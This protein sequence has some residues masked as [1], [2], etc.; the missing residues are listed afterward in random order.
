MLAERGW[1][2]RRVLASGLSVAISLATLRIG[3]RH[4]HGWRDWLGFATLLAP[5]A[6]AAA[7]IWSRRVGA[8]ILARACWWSILA[9]GTLALVMTMSTAPDRE[10]TQM[11]VGVLCASGALLAVGRS[12]LDAPSGRFQPVAF[13][14]T[15][16]LSLLLAMADCGPFG[17]MSLVA[18]FS[19][20]PATFRLLSVGLFLLTLTGVVGLLRLKTWGLLVAIVTNLL[21]GTLAWAGVFGD[22]GP[23]RPLFMTTAALQLVVPLPMIVTF[24]RRRPAPPDRWQRFRAVGAVAV[25]LGLTALSVY[26]GLVR[27]TPPVSFID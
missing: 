20:A 7:L 22:H 21:V 9:L 5:P 16:L 17:F 25:I 4:M 3:Y 11:L 6:V 27:Q 8:Q 13:R 19:H 23:L 15:L 14:G 1:A 18:V 12:G 26:A 24:V 10:R 2:S